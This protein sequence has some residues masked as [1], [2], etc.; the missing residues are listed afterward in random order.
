MGI[1]DNVVESA[2]S[3]DFVIEE[4]GV[5]K[6]AGRGVGRERVEA[7]DVFQG[8]LAT[9]QGGCRLLGDLVFAEHD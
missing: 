3:N 4:L 9:P 5:G 7:D 6:V 8:N 2:A 1:Y